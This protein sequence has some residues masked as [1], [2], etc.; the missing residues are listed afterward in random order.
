MSRPV[1]RFAAM[2]VVTTAGV[3]SPV[4]RSARTRG[5]MRAKRRIDAGPLPEE[6]IED[7]DQ[8]GESGLQARRG[9][10]LLS[11][12]GV[13]VVFDNGD[14][15]RE[16]RFLGCGDLPQKC[17]ARRRTLDAPRKPVDTCLYPIEPTRE[18]S[19]GG[20]VKHSTSS[21]SD[22]GHPALREAGTPHRT[23]GTATRT[24]SIFSSTVSFEPVRLVPTRARASRGV[25]GQREAGC[26]RSRCLRPCAHRRG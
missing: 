8:L 11:H 12:T 17:R 22:N 16:Q 5:R 19:L 18:R 26:R 24:S 15:H 13:G 21:L 14:R 7:V 1:R 10:S 6:S 4:L 9:V 20:S 23:V 2:S 3:D 25:C